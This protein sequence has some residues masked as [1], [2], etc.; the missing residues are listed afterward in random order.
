MAAMIAVLGLPLLQ[1]L[2]RTQISHAYFDENGK[3]RGV[4]EIPDLSMEDFEKNLSGEDK[5][6]FLDLIR[7]M[8][9]WVPEER[10]TAR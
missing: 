8:L 3:W 9:H 1:Y 5:A 4:T 6:I 7:K 10:Q 2:Q